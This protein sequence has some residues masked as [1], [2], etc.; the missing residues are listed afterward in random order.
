MYI[1][2]FFF[3]NT[4]GYVEDQNYFIYDNGGKRIQEQNK[5]TNPDQLKN[6]Q[7]LEQLFFQD[8]LDK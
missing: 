5:A 2:F 7:A 6:G 1:K 4:F 8:Y 3:N